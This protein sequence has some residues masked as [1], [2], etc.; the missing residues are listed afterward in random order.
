MLSTPRSAFGTLVLCGTLVAAL[1]AR[2]PAQSAATPTSGTELNTM[3]E[4]FIKEFQRISLNTTPGDAQLLRIL[5]ESSRAKRG[6]EVGTCT[7]YG[8]LFM[9][10]G[11]ERN[12]GELITV[13]IDP[14]M[15]AKA[16]DNLAKVQLDKT[17]TV[18]EGD[19]LVVLP[20][21]EGTFD[22][23]FIDAVKKDY[24]KYFEAIEG[25]LAPGAVIVADNVIRSAD[26]MRDFLDRVSTDPNYHATIVRASDEKNDGMAI[27]YKLR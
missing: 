26:A 14:A 12:G 27:V 4:R 1:A 6:L 8:A 7:G 23:V 25:K 16:R 17:V 18:V 19:A 20:K 21:L 22:F 11:F 24:L 5:V 10:M 15:V 9:G 13:D 2:A 3:R